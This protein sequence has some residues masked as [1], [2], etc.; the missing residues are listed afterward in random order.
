MLPS[1]L[2]NDNQNNFSKHQKNVNVYCYYTAILEVVPFVEVVLLWE[3]CF[4][5]VFNIFFNAQTRKMARINGFNAIRTWLLCK[6]NMNCT[7]RCLYRVIYVS[8]EIKFGPIVIIRCI[9]SKHVDYK[10]YEVLEYKI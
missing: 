6:V 4:V 2:V 3:V 10:V 9:K 1:Y 8:I 7:I 5:C